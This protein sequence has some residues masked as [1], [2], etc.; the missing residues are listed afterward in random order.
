MS[1]HNLHDELAAEFEPLLGYQ[2]LQ[3][4]ARAS[5]CPLPRGTARIR[6]RLL[7]QASQGGLETDAR[8]D[9][10]SSHQT[11]RTPHAATPESARADHVCESALRVGVR[12]VLLDDALLHPGLHAPCLSEPSPSCEAC[13]HGGRA[14]RVVSHLRRGV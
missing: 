13:P 14:P 11:S 2:R 8:Y 12:S 6:P 4:S 5:S 1:W 7:A 10:A 9:R 3:T